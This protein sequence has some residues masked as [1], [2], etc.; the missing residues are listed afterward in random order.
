MA[1]FHVSV[2]PRSVSIWPALL[3]VAVRAVAKLPVLASRPPSNVTAPAA[4]PRLL[5][6][7]TCTVPPCK[8]VPPV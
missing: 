8:R 5:S 2:V 3:S 1:P 7:D 6:R 4:W